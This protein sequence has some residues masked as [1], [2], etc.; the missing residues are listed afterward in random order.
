MISPASSTKR[1]KP[2]LLV[3]RIVGDSML[4]NLHSGQLVLLLSGRR[5]RVG[6]IVML[7]HDGLEKIKRIARMEAGR[8]YVLGDNPAAST[9]SRQFGWVGLEQVRATLVLPRLPRR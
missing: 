5:P 1:S 4:P 2:S 9:D 6:G 8:V 7:R 3:R